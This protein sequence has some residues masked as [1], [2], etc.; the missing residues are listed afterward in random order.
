MCPLG[1]APFLKGWD[2]LD[3]SLSGVRVIKF[4]DILSPYVASELSRLEAAE[5][6]G[7]SERMSRRWRRHHEDDRE[8]RILD[9]RHGEAPAGGFRPI[10]A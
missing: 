1:L 2:R 5:L 9:R 3:E 4:A 6:V 8:A 10:G 7:I